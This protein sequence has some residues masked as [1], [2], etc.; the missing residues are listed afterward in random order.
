MADHPRK[1]IRDALKAFLDAGSIVYNGNPVLTHMN[2][3]TPW[4]KVQLPAI[5]IYAILERPIDH[6]NSAPK[7]YKRTFEIAT[8]VIVKEDGVNPVDDIMDIIALQIEDIIAVNYRLNIEFVHDINLINTQIE[9][10]TNG[11]I[12]Y[13]AL[14]N[15]WE[16]IYDHDAP[17]SQTL[18]DFNGH[19]SGIG[20]DGNVDPNAPDIAAEVTF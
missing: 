20:I 15:I 4:W 5:G 19:E 8:E 14:I 13:T 6:N 9:K 10:R 3:S 1:T 7:W 12:E 11:D 2:R 17:V 16:I 18:D